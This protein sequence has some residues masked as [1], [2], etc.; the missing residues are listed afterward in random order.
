MHVNAKRMLLSPP[1]SLPCIFGVLSLH[2]PMF[3]TILHNATSR[4]LSAAAA[5]VN[6]NEDEADEL[7]ALE[8]TP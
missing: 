6:T 7:A 5:A 1:P 3:R 2:M 4:F 8:V